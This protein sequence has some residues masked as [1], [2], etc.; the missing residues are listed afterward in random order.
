M[1]DII[2]LWVVTFLVV[3]MIGSANAAVVNFDDLSGDQY[4]ISGAYAGLTW[5]SSDTN[6]SNGNTGY[7][8]A[9]DSTTYATA[10]SPDNYVFNIRGVDNLWFAFSSPVTFNGAWFAKPFGAVLGYQATQVRLRDDNE[11]S[12]WFDLSYTPQFFAVNFTNSSTI[13][14]ERQGGTGGTA[15]DNNN[16]R[17]Y[18]MDDVTYNENIPTP[19]PEPATMFL[20][21]LGLMGIAGI[22]RKFKK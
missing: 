6:S 3:F 5:G 1:K 10:Q 21:G 18:T 8:A 12:A 19:T 17:W 7:F 20:L 9:Y 15:F 2:R 14:V 11:T 22:R 4:E 16:A 13:W